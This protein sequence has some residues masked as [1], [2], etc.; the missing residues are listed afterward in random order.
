MGLTGAPA[1]LWVPLVLLWVL[2]TL[3]EKRSRVVNTYLENPKMSR[4]GAKYMSLIFA[5]LI[6]ACSLLE[7]DE[8]TFSCV[9][10]RIDGVSSKMIYKYFRNKGKVIWVTQDGMYVGKEYQ[11]DELGDDI[12]WKQTLG[13]DEDTTFMSWR[14][15]RKTMEIKSTWGSGEDGGI[16]CYAEWE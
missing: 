8:E 2:L 12:L 14:L 7:K 10:K 16:E 11:A 15:D 4:S 3:M 6:S 9:I 13:N 1:G 5:A